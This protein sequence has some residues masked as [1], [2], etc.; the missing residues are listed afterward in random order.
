[1]LTLQQIAQFLTENARGANFGRAYFRRDGIDTQFF[2]VRTIGPDQA[3]HFMCDGGSVIPVQE[4]DTL[5]Q[6]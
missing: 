1:M 5:V 2:G 6:I 3:P 4:G